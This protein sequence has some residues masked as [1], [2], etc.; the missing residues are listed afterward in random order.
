M[1]QHVRKEVHPH[2][3]MFAFS[4][5]V[6][7]KQRVHLRV[8]RPHALL[9]VPNLD[10]VSLRRVRSTGTVRLRYCGSGVPMHWN[11]DVF[12]AVYVNVYISSIPFAFRIGN[13]EDDGLPYS[14][15]LSKGFPAFAQFS[16]CLTGL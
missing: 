5:F 3:E 11:R 1:H 12:V 9:A 8:R 13:R 15:A 2:L 6:F 10:Q 16:A 7:I 4:E 14:I